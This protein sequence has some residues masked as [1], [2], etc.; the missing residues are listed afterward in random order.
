M[1]VVATKPIQVTSQ[2]CIKVSDKNRRN[3]PKKLSAQ[4][5]ERRCRILFTYKEESQFKLKTDIILTLN[6]ALQK[7]GIKPKIWFT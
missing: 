2:P 3:G 1:I 6:K 4:S 7:A 5:E